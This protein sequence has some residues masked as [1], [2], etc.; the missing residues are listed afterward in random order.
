VRGLRAALRDP[1][2]YLVARAAEIAAQT[3]DAALVPDMLEVYDGLFEDAAKRDPQVWG[4]DALARALRSL[5]H[6]DPAPF[7]R[8]LHHVQL[9]PVWGKLVD[10]AANLRCGCA[11]ALVDTDLAPYDALGELVAVLVDPFAVVR[12]EAV[13]A[14]AQIGGHEA[15][16]LLRLKALTRDAEPE[17]AGACFAALL[18]REPDRALPF[19]A[20]F[21]DDEDDALKAEAA[22]SLALSRHPGALDEVRRFLARAPSREL[23][24]ATVNACAG[25][26]QPE[27]VDLL[28]EL[29]AGSDS[30]SAACAIGALAQ[31]RF[32]ESVRERAS[33][34]V[35]ATRDRRLIAV[36]ED[37][38]GSG[39]DGAAR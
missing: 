16:L 4:K 15:A 28:L 37:A 32:R 6:R 31:S 26:P 2:A 33:E 13:N 17:V 8:G 1:S 36:C 34:A 7:L 14:I 25:C 19:V 39:G 3:G 29:I 38:F 23:R 24:D 30:S 22:A 10:M 21:L 35:R 9:E 20:G 18:D 11:Q 5:G 12:V 27:I